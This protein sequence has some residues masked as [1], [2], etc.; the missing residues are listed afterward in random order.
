MYEETVFEN[1]VR[2]LTVEMPHAYSVAF[3]VWIGVGSRY[4]S[5]ELAGASHFI[6]HMLF[7]GTARRPTARD[8]ALAIEGIGGVCN[9]STGREVTTYWAKVGRGHLPR[10][11]DT[12]FD[13]LRHSRFDP[14]EVEKERQIIIEEINETLDLPDELVYLQ[15]Y[16]LL[17]PQHPLGRDIAG[18]RESVASLSRQA[19]LEYMERHYI[20]ANTIVSVAGAVSHDT[21]RDL[22]APY[23][24]EWHPSPVPTYLPAAAPLPGPRAAA[25]FR[26][27][28]QA[29][30]CLGVRTFNRSH[31]DRYALYLLNAILGDGMSSRLFV[32]IRERLGLA[33]NIY[34]S[35]DLLRDTGAFVVY[36][37]VAP[38][39]LTAAVRAVLAEWDRVRQEEVAPDE[40]QLAKEYVKGHLLLRLED[41]TANA[42][43]VGNQAA[44]GIKVKSPEETLRAVDEVTAADVRR[45]AG[46]LL[47]EAQMVLSL[48]GP[49]DTEAD[50][51][52]LIRFT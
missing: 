12:I 15:L 25:L 28:E 40:L 23:L 3:G 26:D 30:F 14:T 45:V 22:V 35:V 17:W 11:A 7:K 13:M 43:W 48:V 29:H 6:E 8:V 4:E 10:A 5:D 36:A 21:V 34:S 37:G 46:E 19:L 31:P 16:E 51:Q 49:V 2:L 18:T 24:R 33:Y 44:M 9:A 1:G 52:A 42:S 39:N 50:G 38:E 20:P 47:R 41:T 27:I 32:E